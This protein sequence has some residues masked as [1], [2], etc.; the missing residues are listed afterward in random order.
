MMIS[1]FGGPNHFFGMADARVT[2]FC[3]Q[4]GYTKY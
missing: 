2:K 1:N 4:V 3:T